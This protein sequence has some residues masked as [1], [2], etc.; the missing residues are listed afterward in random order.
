MDINFKMRQHG[1][2]SMTTSSESD[3]KSKYINVDFDCFIKNTNV[4][5]LDYEITQ[6][7]F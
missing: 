7:Q 2:G 4:H 1:Y 5:K 6:L 3:Y